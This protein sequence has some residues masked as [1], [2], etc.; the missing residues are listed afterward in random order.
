MQHAAVMRVKYLII[1]AGPTGLG[2]A[3]RLRELGEDSF[4]VLEREGH[5]GGLAAS[6]VD[7]DGF[8][9]DF[10]G[11][12]LFSHY[13]Y[14]DQLAE[15]LLGGEYF[16]HQRESWVRV[17]G[18]W[19]PYPFQNNIRHLPPEERWE[20]VRGLL[21]DRRPEPAAGWRPAH[22][23]E[24]IDTVFGAGIARVFM[25]PYNFKVWATPPERMAYSWIGERVSLVDLETVLE[26][27]VLERDDVAWGPNNTFLFPK[28]GGTGA[29]FQA[30]ARRVED[31]IHYGQAVVRIDGPARRAV[32]DQGLEVEYEALLNTGPLDLLARRWLEQP[33]PALADAAAKLAHNSVHIT[34]VGVDGMDWDPRHNGRDTR[35]WMYFPEADAPFYRVTN[36]HHYSPNN[37]ARPGSQRAIMCET[38]SSE[39][40]PE[41]VEDLMERTLQG[42][43]NTDLLGPDHRD[44][45]AARFEMSREYAYPVPTLERDQAL[46]VIQPRL[47]ALKIYSRGR[48]GGWKYEVG[49]MDHS[50]M[51]GVE[52]AQRMLEA[53]QETTYTL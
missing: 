34:G 27:I 13:E 42:L 9:W 8:T 20:C 23:G 4:A 32:T 26:N 7:R 46:A 1:G 52:W 25:R 45:L 49:N 40:K 15:D 11:H 24:W 29:I 10:G 51:Q 30:L 17:A 43:E 39:H 48:F 16:E 37:T 6:F 21:P 44:R 22:F 50:V 35:C 12:V 5:P 33:D 28:K 31:R 36:F 41:N 14:F 3:N 53:G 2:A 18:T 19:V 47:E 38:S